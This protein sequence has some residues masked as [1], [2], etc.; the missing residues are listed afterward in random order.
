MARLVVSQNERLLIHLME[1]DEHRDEP[2]VPL[3]VCQEGIAQRLQ[4]QVHTVSRALSSFQAEGLVNGRLAHVRGA[5]RRRKTYFLT[6]KGHKA[7]H[8][9]R[10]QLLKGRLIFEEN[11]RTVEISL[12]EI[13][14][15]LSKGRGGAIPFLYLVDHACENEILRSGT[16]L[17][18][19]GAG[20]K[21]R[22]YI[23]IGMGRP[24]AET[25]FGRDAELGHLQEWIGDDSTHS[26]L[27]SGMAGIGKTSL[28][29]R[30]FEDLSGKSHV[31]WYSLHTWDT[32]ERVLSVLTS[33][34]RSL[35]RSEASECVSR[36]Y[37]LGDLFTPL[38]SDLNGAG[39]V[40]FLDD[41]HKAS[42]PLQSLLAI[43]QDA[44]GASGSSKLVLLSRSR[45]QFYS[46]AST[47]SCELELKVLDDAS[48]RKY[49]ES[50]KAVDPSLVVNMSRGHPL[51][52]SL[53]SRGGITA[54]AKDLVTFI[55]YEVCATL[56]PDERSLLELLSIYRHPVEAVAIIDQDDRALVSLKS[57]GLITEQETGLWTHDFLRDFFLSRLSLQS[58]LLMHKNAVSYCSQ[59]SGID[60]QLETLF[61]HVEARDWDSALKYSLEHAIDIAHE[62]PG[63]A[64][65]L[66]SRVPL[67][68]LDDRTR[69]ETTFLR[70]Q[71]KEMNNDDSR[72]ADDYASALEFITDDDEFRASILESLG[73]LKS[74]L[75][76]WNES[77]KA[78]ESALKLY[79]KSNNIG[80]QI[81][82]WLN[83]GGDFRKRQEFGDA[84]D[85]YSRALT[86]ASKKED[87]PAQAACLNNIALLDWDEGRMKDAER[88]L[89]ESVSLAHAVKDHRGEAK[90]LENLAE[91]LRVQL[92]LSEMTCLLHESAEAFRRANEI[93]DYKRLLAAC[94]ESLGM[95]GMINDGIDLCVT[96]FSR[97][98]IRK[99]KG[100][101]GRPAF[102]YGDAALSFAL[103]GLFRSSSSIKRGLE[104]TNRLMDI[105]ES[106]DD[107]TLHARGGIEIALFKEESGDIESA[108]DELKAAEGLLLAAGDKE[109]LIA[110]R[111]IRGRIDEGRGEIQ[112]AREHYMDAVRHA[113]TL[114]NSDALMIANKRLTDLGR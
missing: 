66:V 65:S 43:L 8:S 56:S 48:A 42:D 19:Y 5:P 85:A 52:L 80:G 84:R 72:A 50:A 100:L 86:L 75:E 20:E 108:I 90:G 95:Q 78:H 7:A 94:A 69:A 35:D 96:A 38:V 81:R 22:Q 51:L 39:A 37:S 98:E 105:A 104:E 89:K 2:E 88:R 113:E 76:E 15:R 36:G 68:G 47:G 1:F 74:Q 23:A 24:I 83:L 107:P 60:W 103:M 77:F 82:E 63:E 34:L 55:E 45:P 71:L 46:K 13:S 114:E 73:N 61:H 32:E 16:I 11:G 31:F 106:L 59:N 25:L 26:I 44:V 67:D 41:V 93:E 87:R 21:V 28:A 3:A 91:L 110:V 101:M 9:I 64:L 97:Q 17:A 40:I 92:R 111:M 54:V 102:D 4:I 30:V 27:I 79:E 99:R 109:G 49:A 14:D 70:G 18:M 12:S 29:S 58:K 53:M 10:D 57:K 6:D 62:F 33:F 112:S